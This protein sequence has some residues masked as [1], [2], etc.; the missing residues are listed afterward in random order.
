MLKN[1]VLL[2]VSQIRKNKSES[3]YIEI[4]AAKNGC[5]K[6]FDT[7][8]SFSNQ[9]GGGKIVFGID[10]SS[11]YEICGVYDAADLQKKIMEQSQQMEPSVRPLCTVADIDGKTIVCAEIQEIDNYLKPCFYKGAGR[12]KGSYIRVGDADR[13]MSE[14]EV[15]SYEAFKKKIQDELRPAERASYDD[16][17]TVALEKYLLDVK[18]KKKNLSALP[19]EK[20]CRLQ[21][22]TT[23]GQP[24]LAGIMLFSDYPQAFYPQ[25]CITAVSVPGTEM[26]MVGSVGERFIDN[27]RI[28]GT[29][30]Q[31]LDEAILFVRKNTR[32][33]TIIDPDTGKRN[34][35]SDYPTEAV[36]ELILNALVHRDYS[37]HTDSAPITIRIYSDRLEIENPGGLYGRMTLDQLGKVSADTR[38]P[39]IANALELM[40]VTENRY[41]GIPTVLA[42]MENYGLPAPKFESERGVF[43][44]TLYN[45]DAQPRK[46]GYL[47]DNELLILDFCRTPRSRD[48]LAAL[49][50]GKMTIAYVMSK[51]V[52]KLIADGNL[53]LTIPDKPKSKMQKY[54]SA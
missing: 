3:N 28:D 48:E 25:L 33:K 42:A 37:I 44:V 9:Q 38:N 6:I 47:D 41:S 8:S 32:Q 14:Y 43:R 12:L 18:I 4:K 17:N 54:V 45:G 51:Y 26:S 31:M 19:D 29:L 23:D 53:K 39:F 13:Q 46:E 20:I 7:L 16:L 34:D 10:E 2:L 50:D 24:T 35:R 22:F 5:P 11:N 40:G 52:H 27:K 15:Y 49:F 1:D 30:T 36:R 21:G